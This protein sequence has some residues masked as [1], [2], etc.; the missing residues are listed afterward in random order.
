MTVAYA[1]CYSA[2][3]QRQLGTVEGRSVRVVNAGVPGYSLFQGFVYLTRRG[4]LLE[5]DAVL[6]YFGYNDFLPVAFRERWD[7]RARD[8]GKTDRELFEERQGAWFRLRLFIEEHSNLY[9]RLV[10]PRHPAAVR[11][12]PT[13]LRVP[14]ADRRVLLPKVPRSPSPASGLRTGAG[15]R[16]RRPTR[17]P[18]PPRGASRAVLQRLSM[19]CGLPITVA[20]EPMLAAVTRATR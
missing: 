9:R 2:L 1:D 8:G 7:A 12:D 3:L 5:P 20:V 11:Q 18:Q 4:V 13:K 6:V 19:F 10:R 15:R 17:H 16:G 14:E